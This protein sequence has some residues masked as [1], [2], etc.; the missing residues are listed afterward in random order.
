MRSGEC[1]LKETLGTTPYVRSRTTYRVGHNRSFIITYLFFS[2]PCARPRCSGQTWA[3]PR[4]EL[5]DLGQGDRPSG[6]NVAY[7]PE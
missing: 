2:P 1:R 3:G 7:C 4:Y 6:P 5:V